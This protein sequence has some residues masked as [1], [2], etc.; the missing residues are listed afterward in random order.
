[1]RKKIIA[2]NWKMN[3]LMEEALRLS[4]SIRSQVRS[5]EE[6]E[7]ILFPPNVFLA[8]LSQPKS[9]VRTGAQNFYPA[10]SGAFTGEISVKQVVNCGAQY[11][12][13]GHSER[14]HLFS[15]NHDFLKRK[16]NAAI[17]NGLRVV[18]CCGEPLEIRNEG[19]EHVFVREQLEESLF[20][21]GGHDLQRVIVAYEPVWAIGTGQTATIQQA[22]NMHKAIRQ[23]LSDKYSDE[24][25]QTVPIVYG[26]SCNASNASELFACENVDG[27]LIGGAS[28][29]AESFLAIVNAF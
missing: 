14:R 28:L 19:K 5:S 13:I 12:L 17:E 29:E 25:A 9:V 10:D 2:G 8:A 7:V 22:E 24:V 11:V 1:M 15:E 21:L 16:V 20:H 6:K 18:F 27:G 23:W 3:L 26:G 4:E